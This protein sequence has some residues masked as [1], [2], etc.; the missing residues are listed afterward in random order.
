MSKERA[1]NLESYANEEPLL[2]VPALLKARSPTGREG[3][4]RRIVFF[5]DRRNLGPGGKC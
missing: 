1:R 5:P 3:S 2:A 4:S